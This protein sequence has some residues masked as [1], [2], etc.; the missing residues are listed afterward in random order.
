MAHFSRSYVVVLLCVLLYIGVNR[1]FPRE[2]RPTRPLLGPV[3]FL[4][5]GFGS[6]GALFPHA[7][8]VDLFVTV[9]AVAVGAAFGWLHARRWAL[10]YRRGRDGL[11]VRLPGDPSLLAMIVVTFAAE[12]FMHYAVE[13]GQPWA[14][15]GAFAAMSYALWGVLVGMPL[16]R[17]LNVAMRCAQYANGLRV[18]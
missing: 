15:T 3:I 9:V 18:G 7:G 14:A 6:L 10:Q 5:T 1:C 12:S 2:V 16:G 11:L 13:S 8:D 4:A 17:G